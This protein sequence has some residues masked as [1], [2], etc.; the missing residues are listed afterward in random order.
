MTFEYHR[1]EIMDAMAKFNDAVNNAS[2]DLIGVDAKVDETGKILR[3]IILSATLSS[4][5]RVS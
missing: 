4:T 1:K 3:G 5:L 2:H